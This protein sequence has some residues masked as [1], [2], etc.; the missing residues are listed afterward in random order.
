[1]TSLSADLDLLLLSELNPDTCTAKS[2]AA[3][4]A[5]ESLSWQAIPGDDFFLMVEGYGPT[6]GTYTLSV[7]CECLANPCRPASIIAVGGDRTEPAAATRPASG[8]VTAAPT[9]ARRAP[10]TARHQG[11]GKSMA[12]D[13]AM[14]TRRSVA[15][16][17]CWLP[18]P[19]ATRPAISWDM[20]RPG[21]R[22]PARSCRPAFHA[23]RMLKRPIC[24]KRPNA[25][26]EPR[27]ENGP[28]P[29]L[30]RCLLSDQNLVSMRSATP[31]SPGTSCI[32]PSGPCTTPRQLPNI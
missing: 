32:M 3:G 31:N 19:A 10:R 14:E 26:N 12:P 27:P 11:A 5:D 23:T 13:T 24:L 28:F 17:A 22:T 18:N 8:L 21:P 20:A 1:M 2:A 30:M 6:T 29:Q 15:S 16:T 4:M 25:S 7:T 9:G